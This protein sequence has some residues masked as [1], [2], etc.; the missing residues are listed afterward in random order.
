MITRRNLL[1]SSIIA[2]FTPI[3]SLFGKKVEDDALKLVLQN[4]D[5]TDETFSINIKTKKTYF[6]GKPCLTILKNDYISAMYQ[7]NDKKE[8]ANLRFKIQDDK[9][10]IDYFNIIRYKD[11]P[12]YYHSYEKSS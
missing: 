1:A 5:G 4:P 12:K 6:N 2:L 7:S 9:L 11:N 3:K 10:I 8:E